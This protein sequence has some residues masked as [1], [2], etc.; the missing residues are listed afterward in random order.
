MNAQFSAPPENVLSRARPFMLIEV[1]QFAF[2]QPRCH[3]G[4]KPSSGYQQINTG[5]IAPCQSQAQPF[6]DVWVT[7]S[8]QLNESLEVNIRLL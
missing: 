8:Q 7:T 4:A 6:G 3:L 2:V 1:I 5:A